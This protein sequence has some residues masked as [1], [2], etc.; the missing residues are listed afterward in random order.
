MPRADLE[1]GGKVK[2]K[3]EILEASAAQSAIQR[4]MK[5]FIV[6]LVIGNAVMALHVGQLLSL[7]HI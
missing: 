4:N 2:T 1:R 3:E 6:L 5:V 7:I